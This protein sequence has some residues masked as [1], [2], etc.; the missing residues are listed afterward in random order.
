MSFSWTLFF[1]YCIYL[2]CST[3]LFGS[4][5]KLSSG[6]DDIL[7]INE[8]TYLSEIDDLDLVA[9]NQETVTVGLTSVIT[10]AVE[11]TATPKLKRTGELFPHSP[12][13]TDRLSKVK[14]KIVVVNHS[15]FGKCKHSFPGDRER[16]HRNNK[17]NSKNS[18]VKKSHLAD[19]G[20]VPRK[21]LQQTVQKIK[22]RE[23]S[24]SFQTRSAVFIANPPSGAH[25]L[26]K[27]KIKP[28]FA[29]INPTVVNPLG[30]YHIPKKPVT[31]SVSASD[32]ANRTKSVAKSKIVAPVKSNECESKPVKLSRT[33]IKNRNRRLACKK[34]K[35]EAKQQQK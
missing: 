22:N 31:V 6:A 10:T 7:Q 33:Q 2:A 17:N 32:S 8:E 30:N 1:Y 18:R 12:R 16:K 11:P 29:H 5:A 25:K 20:K 21:N 4:K 13:K 14:S 3:T 35:A 19:R 27:P 9:A 28:L 34:L 26:P 23:L 24:K 15:A